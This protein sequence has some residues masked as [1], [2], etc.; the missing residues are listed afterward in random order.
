MIFL[1]EKASGPTSSFEASPG[2]GGEG[3][4]PN[5]DLNCKGWIGERRSEVGGLE[6]RRRRRKR[7]RGDDGGGRGD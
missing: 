2:E 1:P 4:M 3:L 5:Q 7:K 6:V